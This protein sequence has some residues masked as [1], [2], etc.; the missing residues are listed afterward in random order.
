MEEA[1]TDLIAAAHAKGIEEPWRNPQF[2]DDTVELQR[3]RQL[4]ASHLPDEV[5]F[6][7]RSVVCT[8]ALAKYLEY[9]ISQKLAAELHRIESEQVYERQVFFVRNP[10]FIT[11]TAARRISYEESLRFEQIHEE[12]YRSVG[13]ELVFVDTGPLVD[14]VAAI[15]ALIDAPVH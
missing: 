4:R 1:A 3:S 10:G 6:H 12:T 2:I 5:Q 14:R 8:A 13:F 15:R 11:P 7:D 9:P